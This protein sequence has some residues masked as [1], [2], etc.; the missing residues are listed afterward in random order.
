VGVAQQRREDWK[1]KHGDSECVARTHAAEILPGQNAK[2]FG[3]ACSPK[4]LQ[5]YST[6]KKTVDDDELGDNLDS[7]TR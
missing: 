4:F 3:L 6:K 1:R 5:R 2:A 7:G